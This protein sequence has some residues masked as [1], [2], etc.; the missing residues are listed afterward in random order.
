MTNDN[1]PSDVTPPA[2]GTGR[3]RVRIFD[4]SLRDG[5]QAPGFSMGRAAKLRLAHALE[6]LGVDVLEAGFPSASDGDFEAVQAIAREVRRP[7]VCGLARCVPGDIDACARALAP[8]AKARIHLFLAT[9]PLHREFKLGMSREQVIENAVAAVRNACR[10]FDDVEFSAEDAIRT[11]PDYL[12]EVFSAVI[13]AG[14]RTVNVPDT[15][16]YT[17]PAEMYERVRYLRE[18]VHGIDQAVLSTHCHD[19]LGLAVANSL[20]AV[21]AGAR[22]VE[23]TIGGIGERAGNASLEEIVMALA[24]RAEL[25][26][27]DTGIDTRKLYP[28]ARLLGQLTGQPIARN[29]AVVGENA[30]AH[31]S[32]I[33]QHGMLKHRGT[34]EI[35]KPE[36]V[37]FSRSQLV[38]GKH[39]GRHALRERLAALGYAPDEA[40]LDAIFTRFKT[41]ADR[42]REVFDSDLEALAVGRDPEAVGPWHLEHLNAS[43]HLGGNGSASVRLVHEDGRRASEAA[44]GD[45]PIDAVLRAIGRAIGHD[46]EL[47]DFQIRALSHGGDAQGQATLGVRHQDRELKGRGVSTD[48][49]EA[50]ALAALE[51]ANRIERG[52][53]AVPLR[54]LAQAI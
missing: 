17:T 28:T 10:H 24:T 35:M 16:G 38:L 6:E 47:T 45:G 27:V 8:A 52:T 18:H 34:Y 37:G 30:F 42:K 26:G 46:L 19:D 51:I 12:V 50:A 11:E 48:I 54:Q 7:I 21:A 4:T 14:A 23:C 43:S 5:E 36:D 39:S 25:F 15:V 40:Q 2:A 1:P 22:Q 32:G 3:E 33:H 9:S 29:K 20:A 44:I 49:V 13:A 31:E 53:P 41:L